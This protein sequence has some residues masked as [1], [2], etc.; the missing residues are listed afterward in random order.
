MGATG[1]RADVNRVQHIP[2]TCRG[3][4]PNF[5]QR[6][7]GGRSGPCIRMVEDR[8]SFEYGELRVMGIAGRLGYLDNLIFNGNHNGE[9]PFLH[10]CQT[11]ERRFSEL[12]GGGV[13]QRLV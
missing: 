11:L 8:G 9:C 5:G 2:V 1:L 12:N 4:E 10:R 6:P 7:C 13:A 3:Q